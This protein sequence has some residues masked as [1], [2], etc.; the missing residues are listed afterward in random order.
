M[1]SF[2]FSRHKGI[3]AFIIPAAAEGYSLGAKEDKLG[4]RASSTANVILENV[5]V[6]KDSLLGSPGEGFKIAMQVSCFK[7]AGTALNELYWVF[8]NKAIIQPSLTLVIIF[9]S[10]THLADVRWGKVS[11]LICLF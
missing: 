5:R 8:L 2:L 1:L 10:A 11:C 3:S 6:P 7:V 4:I 9:P